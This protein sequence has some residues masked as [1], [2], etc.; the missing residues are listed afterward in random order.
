MALIT[1]VLITILAYIVLVVQSMLVIMHNRSGQSAEALNLRKPWHDGG[2]V[3]AHVVAQGSG[4]IARCDFSN[5]FL[6]PGGCEA[7][8]DQRG[9][10]GH[11]SQELSTSGTTSTTR[12][13]VV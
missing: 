1:L 2:H 9:S 4:S 6:A 10:Q 5:G 7:R 13:T 12:N 11:A 8:E 3:C